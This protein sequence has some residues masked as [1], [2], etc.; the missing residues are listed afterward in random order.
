ARDQLHARGSH[1]RRPCNGPVRG[2]RHPRDGSPARRRWSDGTTRQRGPGERPDQAG[3]P[4]PDQRHACA[5]PA[6]RG[7]RVSLLLKVLTGLVSLAVMATVAVTDPTG[8]AVGDGT[9]VAP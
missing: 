8:D 1:G 7:G 5:S 3:A 4:G 2:C 6:G 9:I